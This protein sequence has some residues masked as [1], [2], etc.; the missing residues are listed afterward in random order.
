MFSVVI[1]V[2]DEAPSLEQLHRELT[3]VAAERGYAL[4]ILFIDDGSRDNSWATIQSLAARDARVRGLRFRRNFGKAAALQAGFSRARGEL[5]FTLDADLQDDP[6]EMPKFLA[7][8]A[9]GADLVS[10]WKQQRFDPWHKV[11]PSRVFNRMVSRLTGVRLHD[12]NCGY[13]CYRREVLEELRLYGELHR[14]VPVLAAARGWRVAEVVVEHRRRVYGHSKFG[15][16]RIPKGFLDLLTVKFLTSYGQR[17][18]HLF[19]LIGTCLFGLGFLN[20]VVLCATW[21]LSRTLDG[22]IPVHLTQTPYFYISLASA[23][24]GGQFLAAGMV[25]ELLTAQRA[26]E[27]TPYAISEM[28]PVLDEGGPPEGGP[29]STVA[30]TAAGPGA[31]A[32]SGGPSPRGDRRVPGPHWTSTGRGAE[33]TREQP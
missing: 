24:L 12:H 4:E 29:T 23:V 1:P 33:S 7:S 26:S 14:F 18:Q 15:L 10:G 5:I 6:R 20:L 22:W 13:K 31:T 3:E 9:S 28:T 16:W 17:P 25:A 8:L 27:V 30:S 11:W 32:D 2:F 19:G 21:I